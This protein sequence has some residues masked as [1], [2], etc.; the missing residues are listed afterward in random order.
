MGVPEHV[1]ARVREVPREQVR[2]PS[3]KA[4]HSHLLLSFD[5][6]TLLGFGLLFRSTILCTNAAVEDKLE[7]KKMVSR[8]IRTSDMQSQPLAFIYVRCWLFLTL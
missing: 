8:L 1:G 5:Q 7:T 4:C 2:L 6:R 3:R